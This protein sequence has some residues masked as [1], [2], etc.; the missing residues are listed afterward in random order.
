MN[1]NF[2]FIQYNINNMNTYLY[3][4]ILCLNNIVEKKS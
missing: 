4:S 2:I 3:D 1:F